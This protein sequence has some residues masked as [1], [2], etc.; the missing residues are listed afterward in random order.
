MSQPPNSMPNLAP[1]HRPCWALRAAIVA[2]LCVLGGARAAVQLD[3]AAASN[4][5]VPCSQTAELQHLA[6]RVAILG[7][8]R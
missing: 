6:M 8:C 1:T 5:A 4:C 2:L 3:G 7:C